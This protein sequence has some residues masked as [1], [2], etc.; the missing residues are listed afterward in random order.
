MGKKKRKTSKELAKSIGKFLEGKEVNKDGKQR[1]EKAI[2]R[3]V[4]PDSK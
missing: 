1:F 3:A 2:Q 4:K